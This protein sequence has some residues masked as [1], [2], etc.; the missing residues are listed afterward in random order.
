MLVLV[1]RDDNLEFQPVRLRH[2][3]GARLH[4]QGLDRALARGASPDGSVNL[5]LHAARLYRPGHRSAL[6]HTVRRLAAVAARPT[7]L[8]APVSGSAVR[9]VA[10]ELEAVASRLAAP[11]PVDVR[12]VAKVRSLISDGGGPLYRPSGTPAL[13]DELLSVLRA[14]DSPD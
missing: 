3:V 11:G 13:R 12:G 5:A 4:A 2:R 1:E 6:A 8:A 10:D 7:R 9:D 14:F